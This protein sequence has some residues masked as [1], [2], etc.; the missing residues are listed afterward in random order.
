MKFLLI[1]SIFNIL[2][3]RLLLLTFIISLN[4]FSQEDWELPFKNNR[5]QFEFNSRNL[6]NGDKEL[7]ALYTS[8]NFSN[9]FNAKLKQAMTNGKQKF[10]S[11]TNF[12][13][14]TQL[15]GADFSMGNIDPKKMLN[16]CGEGND[17]LI[18][19]I[20][21]NVSR[22]TAF[23]GA[24]SG[25]I[26]CLFRIVLKENSY[27]LKIQGFKFTYYEKSIASVKQKVVKLEEM[28][29]KEKMSRGDKKF[30]ADFKNIIILFNTELES[31]LGSQG[32]DLNFDD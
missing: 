15:H 22:L 13:I 28:F 1:L 4:T 24:K 8:Y 3:M 23:S 19:L 20:N 14:F 17:T 27:E 7:C 32:S 30:W 21:I 29:N 18:G 5:I 16:L 31:Q 6:N 11:S 25:S 9:D 26:K 10:F 12:L 2:K